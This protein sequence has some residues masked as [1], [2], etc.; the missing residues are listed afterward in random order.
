[1]VILND[2]MGEAWGQVMGVASVIEESKASKQNAQRGVTNGW[3]V[4]VILTTD[5]HQS[6]EQV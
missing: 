4:H 6:S 3:S 1:M 5:A 2:L